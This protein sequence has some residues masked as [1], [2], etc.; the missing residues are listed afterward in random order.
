MSKLAQNL[1]TSSSLDAGKISALK[2]A[3]TALVTMFR[4][5]ECAHPNWPLQDFGLHLMIEELTEIVLDAS[6]NSR[7]SRYAYES[8]CMSGV[9]CCRNIFSRA[10][11][12][13]T[14]AA[15]VSG[16]DPTGNDEIWF[17]C[18]GKCCGRARGWRAMVNCCILASS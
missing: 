14:Q 13:I 3:S 15:R 11:V 12:M 1:I 7:R 17:R 4:C 16:S 6:S 9:D 5:L 18:L 2:G 8:L 10:F